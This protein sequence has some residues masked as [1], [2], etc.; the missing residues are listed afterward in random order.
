MFWT[1]IQKNFKSAA[2]KL[3]LVQIM[4]NCSRHVFLMLSILIIIKCIKANDY[5][6]IFAKEIPEL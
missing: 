6:V 4:V 2:T 1:D 3:G 5:V